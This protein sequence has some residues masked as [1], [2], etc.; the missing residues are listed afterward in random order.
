MT[1]SNQTLQTS[2]LPA[3]GLQFLQQSAPRSKFENPALQNYHTNHLHL[4]LAEGEAK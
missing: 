4:F 2:T 1:I 3:N